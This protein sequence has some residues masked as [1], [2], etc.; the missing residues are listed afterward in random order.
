M[1]K[2][3]PAIVLIVCVLAAFAFMTGAI[4]EDLE[5]GAGS[6]LVDE[7]VTDVAT[8]DEPAELTASKFPSTYG[9]PDGDHTLVLY[10]D[11][12]DGAEP[13]A[14]MTGNLATHF[15]QVTLLPFTDYAAGDAEAHDALIVQG[16]GPAGDIPQELVS[17]I[18]S[19]TTPVMW[20]GSHVETLAG[21]AQSPQSDAFIERYGWSPHA[22]QASNSEVDTIEYHGQS[23]A[24]SSDSGALRVPAII[25]P[26]TVEV[27]GEAI[28]DDG[29]FPWTIRSGNLTWVTDHPLIAHAEETHSVAFA[30]L[31]FN[32]LAPE[33]VPSARAAVRLEDIG[34]RSDPDDLRRIADVLAAR[35]IPFQ[36]ATYPIDI[37]HTDS[38]RHEHSAFS[39]ADTPEVV[40]ALKYMQE[41][42]GTIVHHGT[43][44]QYSS[45]HNPYSGESGADY[46]FIDA[47]CS[48]TEQ[49]PYQFEE[50]QT[51]SW[52]RLIGPVAEDSVE[53]HAER[54][55]RGR[56]IFAEAGLEV[57]D[58]FEVPHYGATPNAYEAIGQL[59]DYRYE[60]VMHYPG[61]VSDRDAQMD[62]FVSQIMPYAVTDVYGTTVL[63]E[64]LGNPSE[65]P[66]N[67]HPARPASLIVDNA[68][69][70][71]AVRESTASFFFHPFLDSAILEEILDGI[72]ELGYEFVPA[73]ELAR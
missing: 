26:A 69:R 70:N 20:V 18:L 1:K 30:D 12:A 44:H 45:D 6:P 29:N 54:I 63:P 42:G 43:T 11:A 66:L 35:N 40:E 7:F 2:T 5:P 50:C 46:E 49:R 21:S 41:R 68:E 61:L 51:D 4:D 67:N 52:V 25:D 62:D 15:G 9:D 58:V 22:S 33:T 65:E 31:Y 37:R 28:T 10:N 56:E 55:Q 16:M 8:T 39:L 23:F 64:N 38:N 34:P 73:T 71:L 48:A 24:R 19:S 17:D 59:Y 60:Q 27:L 32:L 36:V 14:I 72:S 3:L 53:D 57:S 13:H 47:R